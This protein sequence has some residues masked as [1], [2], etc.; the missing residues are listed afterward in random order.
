MKQERVPARRIKIAGRQVFRGDR[1]LWLFFIP[2]RVLSL[3]F[4]TFQSKSKYCYA[5]HLAAFQWLIHT[6]S[7]KFAKNL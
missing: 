6:Y 7:L 2:G 5:L 3:Y 1:P 4:S